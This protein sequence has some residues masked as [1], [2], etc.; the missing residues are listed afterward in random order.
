[1][2]TND[3]AVEYD[4]K[5]PVYPHHALTENAIGC[6][7]FEAITYQRPRIKNLNPSGHDRYTIDFDGSIER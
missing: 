2:E 7:D 3:R 6:R 4:L 1:M 5:C